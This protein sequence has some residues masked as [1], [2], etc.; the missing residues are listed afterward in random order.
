MRIPFPVGRA[1]ALHELRER[2]RDRWV[3]VISALFALLASAVGLY[4]RSAEGNVTAITGPSLVTL[5]SLFV[6]LV[7]LAL[8]YD[9]IV[10]ERERNTLGLL[11]SLPASRVEVVLAKFV[12]RGV[13]LA[14]AVGVGLGGAMLAAAQGEARTLA[15]LIGPTIALGLTFVSV[16]ML[17]SSLTSRQSTAASFVIALWFLLVFFYDLGLLALLVATDGAVGDG[18]IASLVVGNPTGLY[19]V[20]LLSALSGPSALPDL[21]LDVSLPSSTGRAALWLAWILGPLVLSGLVLSAR[22][23]L[24]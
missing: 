18:T 21:G 2:T 10:G 19:R 15:A 14:A 6:P 1:L 24:R 11:L 7:A 20:T 16:G 12:G 5:A 4:G 9:A 22:R 17:V 13:A 8:G 23:A 3:L